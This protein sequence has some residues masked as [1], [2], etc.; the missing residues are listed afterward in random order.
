MTPHL[1]VRKLLSQHL[2]SQREM[3]S[4]HLLSGRDRLARRAPAEPIHEQ[5]VGVYDRLDPNTLSIWQGSPRETRSRRTPTSPRTRKVEMRLPQERI[6]DSH[7]ARP[8][9]QIITMMQWIR[10]SSLSKKNSFS[11]TSLQTSN[12]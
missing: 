7:G 5:V 9:H 2:L 3:L 4:Q 10:T 12:T 6:S 1:Q 11:D 8:V